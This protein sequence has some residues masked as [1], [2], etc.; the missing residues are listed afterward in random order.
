METSLPFKKATLISKSGADG[1]VYESNNIIY[2]LSIIYDHYHCI[3]FEKKFSSTIEIIQSLVN[4]P[5][6]A[7]VSVLKFENLLSG[8]REAANNKQKYH[9]YCYQM[10]KLFPLTE[11]EKKVLHSLI[12]H[13][14][15][16]IQKTFD[17]ALATTLKK[18]L[19]FD[20]DKLV[21]FSNNISKSKYLHLDMHDRNIMKDMHGNFKLIDLDRITLKQEK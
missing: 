6:P 20:L 3:D 17:V 19:E 15:N 2:K 13:E 18:H 1:E 4:Y 9:I 21:E 10:P 11:D 7:F 8:Y 16:N 14:D 12:S 5:D